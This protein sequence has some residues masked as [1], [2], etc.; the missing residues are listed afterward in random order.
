MAVLRLLFCLFCLRLE[1]LWYLAFSVAG[2]D[3]GPPQRTSRAGEW[4]VSLGLEEYSSPT[5]VDAR[6]SI[7]DRSPP[8]CPPSTYG[9]SLAAHRLSLP[10]PPKHP[11]SY[12]HR[13]ASLHIKTSDD[14]ISYG[15]PVREIVVSLDKFW[16]G[17]TQQNE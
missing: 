11:H 10:L 12:E 14:Q 16:F 1:R 15:G 13:N 2:V 6:L 8:P 7:V 3:T 17:P 5:W 9:Q 4:L